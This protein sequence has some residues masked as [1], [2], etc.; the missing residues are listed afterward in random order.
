MKHQS[1]SSFA[2]SIEARLKQKRDQ[3]RETLRKEGDAPC[4]QQ[5]TPKHSEKGLIAGSGVPES[6]IPSA[7]ATVEQIA[8]SAV[9][10]L[11]HANELHKLAIRDK[12]NFEVIG[13]AISAAIAPLQ[14]D[15]AELRDK[16]NPQ[17]WTVVDDS[18]A[19]TLS[20]ALEMHRRK[21]EQVLELQAELEQAKEISTNKR[22]LDLVRYMRAELHQSGLITDEEFTW[23]LTAADE[24]KLG[25]GSISA[26]RLEDYDQLRA[27]LATAEAERDQWK[28]RAE[29]NIKLRWI[30]LAE[31]KPTEQDTD[32]FGRVAWM[33]E[34]TSWCGNIDASDWGEVNHWH[35]LPKL[36]PV[37][38]P[39]Q[40]E[41]KDAD[42][43]TL[44]CADIKRRQQF[45]IA[46][47]GTS[48]ANNPLSQQQWL[49]HAYEE[50]LDFAV[51]IKA[52]LAYARKAQ[53]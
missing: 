3:S 27:R 47:Y 7:S 15:N 34:I 5:M 21:A 29:E 35:P 26:R 10:K 13:Q 36:P 8:R 46:K 37:A 28:E 50:S 31:R 39:D 38:A 45:G 43:E 48:V 40:Q 18:S 22:Q 44:V 1:K 25:Q 6:S 2:E 12:N 30:P 42:I 11:L 23:L 14:A 24:G 41:Q 20:E 19:W 49:T 32:K 17:L 53:T 9:G 4:P 33:S 16:L 51:Y 52:A